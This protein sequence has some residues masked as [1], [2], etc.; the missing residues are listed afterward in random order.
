MPIATL[1]AND[2]IKTMKA[3]HNSRW[4]KRGD[5][6]RLSP[7]ARPDF[8]AGCVLPAGGKIFTIGS[9][10][11][12]NVESALAERGFNLPALDVLN[13]D[14]DF[15]AVGPAV[16]NNY[17]APSIYNELKWAFEDETNED[18]CFAQQGKGWVD[19]HLKNS[20]APADLDIVRTRR[21]ALRA[22][23]RS[24]EE[25]DAVIITLGLSE[26]W[27]DTQTGY[28]L[29]LAPRRSMMRDMPERFELH[30]LSYAETCVGVDQTTRA[31]RHSGD[32]HRIPRS[33][34]CNLPRCGC[35]GRQYIFQI[36]AAHRRRRNHAH[37]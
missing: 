4:P 18:A 17:G 3:N 25:C 9:C 2:A 26:V 7:M 13:Q 33:G 6:N 10:F 27:F 14:D 16:M 19:L 5:T 34:D 20:M 1:S 29:N 15:N 12:R 22:A 8:K 28:Y 23:Y 32:C 36:R 37:A 31:R 35:D 11:A 24:I 21:R 30:V